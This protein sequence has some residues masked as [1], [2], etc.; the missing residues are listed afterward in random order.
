[1]T[2]TGAASDLSVDAVAATSVT[3]TSVVTPLLIMVTF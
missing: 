2:A 3:A 1:M